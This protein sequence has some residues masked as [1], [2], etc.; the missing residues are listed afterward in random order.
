MIVSPRAKEVIDIVRIET[1]HGQGG[2]LIEI[3]EVFLY[4]RA[5]AESPYQKIPYWKR[6]EKNTGDDSGGGNCSCHAGHTS[7]PCVIIAEADFDTENFT[8]DRTVRVLNG[9]GNPSGDTIRLD[10][11]IEM[12]EN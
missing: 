2:C 1:R 6:G 8:F 3:D 11:I 4:R 12:E 9:E 5:D 10:H 7:K